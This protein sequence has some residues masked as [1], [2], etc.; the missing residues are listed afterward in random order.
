MNQLKFQPVILIGALRSG[1]KLLRDTI[2]MHS[3]I[4]CVPFEAEYIWHL[5][6][7]KINHD[8]LEVSSITPKIRSTIRR[9]FS[10]L[11]KG[12]PILLEKSVSNCVRLPFVNSIF[13]EAKYIHLV[14]D[15]RDNVESIYRQ[16][17]H[18]P[19]PEYVIKR[20]LMFPW[21]KD[22]AAF[23]YMAYYA[24]RLIMK[25]MNIS[26][27][28][29]GT[30]G[31]RYKGIESDLLELSLLEVCSIQWNQSVVMAMNDFS[32]ISD[33][34]VLTIRYEDFVQNP[35]SELSKVANFLTVD[36]SEYI[37]SKNLQYISPN[38]IGRGFS[39]LKK[40]DQETIIARIQEGLEI[41][42]Y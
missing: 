36:P 4:D 34:K 39:L 30:W 35:K 24:K 41:L 26:S 19:G 28:Q 29:S 23:K 20:L 42:N 21:W 38:N 16:W 7:E 18:S 2:S 5:G 10:A 32:K 8:E 27:N 40:S 14:R 9:K 15:G 37:N 11:S 33:S 22:V 17:I 6:N 12:A 25:N 13:P 1:T 31:V 3:Q